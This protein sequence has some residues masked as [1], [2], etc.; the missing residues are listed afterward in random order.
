MTD[1][2]TTVEETDADAVFAELQQNPEGEE[3]KQSEAPE[4]AKV[5]VGDSEYD[6]DEL[7]NLIAEANRAKEIEKGGREKFDEAANLRK[8]VE[9]EKEELADMRA[10]WNAWTQGTAEERALILSNL[11]KSSGI[12][13]QPDAPEDLEDPTPN[14]LALLSKLR[15]QEAIAKHLIDQLKAVAPVL[16]DVKT[17]TESE[18][19]ERQMAKTLADLKETHGISATREQVQEWQKNGISD[20]VAAF[21]MIKPMLDAAVG[22]GAEKARKDPEIPAATTANTFDPDDPNLDPDEMFRMIQK[23]FVPIG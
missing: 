9:A 19:A 16:N 22:K 7:Q 8:Q 11:Q 14:E 3:T 23:G 2:E 4:G 6:P 1:E 12:A 15:Q 10:I 13:I 21:G 18:K 5:K 20:P 17:F